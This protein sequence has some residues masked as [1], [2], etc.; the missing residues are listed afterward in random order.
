MRASATTYAPPRTDNRR[1]PPR[2]RRWLRNR[3]NAGYLFIAPWLVG[4]CLFM[5]FPLVSMFY[6]SFTS[7]DL[8]SDPEW[9]GAANYV[10][11]F[12]KDPVWVQINWHM[13]AYVCGST[14]VTTGLGLLFAVL[15]AQDFRF[16]HVFRTILYVPTLLV[17]VATGMLFLR[18][19]ANGPVGLANIV[20]SW[21]HIPA[22]NWLQNYDSLWLG[23]LTLILVNLWFTGNAM[24][25]FLAGI[26]GIS[27]SFYEAAQLDGA[28]RFRIFRSV[29][30]PLLSPVLVLN[31]I[32]ILIG[33]I[34]VFD[35]PLTFAAAG[36]GLTTTGSN[37][38]GFQNSL[39]T[40]L[41]YIYQQAFI[42]NNFGYASALA[43]VVF[44]ITLV[45]CL[46]V[47]WTS[48]RFTYYGEFN[49]N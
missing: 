7:Y 4:F 13:L 23:M 37:V 48:N 29:T 21:L 43:V 42:E 39:G 45:L 24:L 3:E 25:I 20:L 10:R 46:A 36:G 12:T 49:N 44:G 15:L 6:H 38:L 41:V 19:F 34:Q 47:L 22:V 17:G 26:K 9:V 16:N 35:T 27:P 5:A 11:I 2:W 31:G 32:L 1:Q 30:L 18:V 8:F 40:Y 14:I 28:G 33:H